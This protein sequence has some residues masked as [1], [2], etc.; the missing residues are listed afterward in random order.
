MRARALRLSAP[1][2]ARLTHLRKEA[3]QDGEYRVAK[4][5]HAVLLNHD[6]HTSGEIARLLQSPRSKVSE[7]LARYEQHGR[8][9]LWEGHRSGRPP[10]LTDPQRQALA[11]ILDSGPRA[12]GFLSAVWNAAMV[13]RVIEEEYDQSYHPRHVRRLLHGLGFSVQRPKRL[14]TRAD[15]HEQ[16]RWRRYT[17]PNLKK[18]PVRKGR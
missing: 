5:L 17:Y 11:D 10:R 12:Y 15:P 13:A 4:R 3:E 16:N 8:E 18:K 6:G 1:T 9:A 7:W 2:Y 14:L